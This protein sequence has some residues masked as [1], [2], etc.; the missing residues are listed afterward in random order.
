VN[1]PHFM[2]WLRHIIIPSPDEIPPP[3]SDLN[4]PH[5]DERQAL[6]ES[7]H[8]SIRHRE[9]ILRTLEAKAHVKGGHGGEDYIDHT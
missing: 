3:L 7:T 4:M 1:F 5:P 2:D 9:R 8:S 6:L